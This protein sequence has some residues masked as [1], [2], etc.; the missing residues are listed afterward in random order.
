MR[1]SYS[2]FIWQ[3]LPFLRRIVKATDAQVRKAA[4]FSYSGPGLPARLVH[5]AVADPA[6]G[7]APELLEA[8]HARIRE[9]TWRMRSNH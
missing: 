4:P 2:L 7:D 1:T 8:H 5:C 6:G 9:L 3:I